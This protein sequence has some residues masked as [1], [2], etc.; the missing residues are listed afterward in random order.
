MNAIA[1]SLISLASMMPDQASTFATDV[2]ALYLFLIGVSMFF[3]ILIGGLVIFFVFRYRRRNDAD[4]PAATKDHHGLEIF[5]TAVPLVLVII[6]FVWGAVIFHR[7]F[8]PPADALEIL[9]TG[10]QWMWKMQHPS[11]R[12][13]INDLHVPLGR[14]VQLT[15]TS[16]DVIHSFYVPAFRTKSD[17]VP[18]RYTST[19]F[20]PTEL[21]AYHLFCAEYCGA[22][23][24]LMKGWV[25]V[26]PA[27]E[28][29]QWARGENLDTAMLTPV[30]AGERL[31]NELGCAVCHNPASGA[32]GPHI[33]GLYEQ[34]V[35]LN[36]GTTVVADEDYLRE[37]ILE[38]M[39]KVVDGYQPI[40]PTYKGQV[41]EEQLMQL[42]AYIKSLA[43]DQWV[44]TNE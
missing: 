19:W 4:R 21:G 24:S 8:R 9:V 35:P 28:Y 23:H 33:A 15:M 10:K 1:H 34:P 30:E 37:S 40:M 27:D 25:Y 12:S 18:G 36:N 17:V 13:E 43:N 31:F 11:G 44:T 14:P 7:Q 38:P 39:T 41:N 32:L 16:E 29:E 5:W 6:M 20:T 22:E 26:I 2:D 42:I 3:C